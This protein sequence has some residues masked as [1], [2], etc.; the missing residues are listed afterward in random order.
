MVHR[1]FNRNSRGFLSLLWKVRWSEFDVVHLQ[2]ETFLYG[3][4]LSLFVLPLVVRWIRHS[5]P[6]VVTLHHVVHPKKIT[7]KFTDIYCTRLPP[8]LIKCGYAFFYRFLGYAATHCIVH[9]DCDQSTLTEAYGIPARKISIIPHGSEDRIIENTAEKKVL[10]EQ[11]GIPADAERIYGFL[12]YMDLSKG[13][14]MLVNEFLDHLALHPR[15][16]LLIGGIPNP[17]YVKQ[18]KLVE[19]LQ[20]LRDRTEHEGH[21]RII[22]R[23]EIPTNHTDAFY[24]LID[25]IIIPYHSFNGGSAALA[26]AISYDVPCLLSE[27]FVE[28][29]TGPAIIFSLQK[30]GLSGALHFCDMTQHLPHPSDPAFKAWREGRLWPA[31][32]AKT[33]KLYRELIMPAPRS[34]IL[35]LGAY[36][37]QNLGD[38]LLLQS[39]L[40]HLPRSSCVVA[41]AHPAETE[42]THNVRAVPSHIGF[43]L[44]RCFLRARIIVVGGGDQFKLLKKSMGR[45]RH[46]LLIRETILVVMAKLLGKKVYFI[47]VGIGAI[48]TRF[49]RLLSTIILRLADIS[50]FR[51]R[52]SARIARTLAPRAQII[53][54]ADLAFLQRSGVGASTAIASSPL[55]LGIAPVFNLDHAEAFPTVT[56]AIG[57]SIDTFLNADPNREVL[58]LPFQTG[59]QNHHDIITSGEILDHVSQRQR[60]A[61]HDH[62]DI[63]TVEQTYRSINML[64]GMRLH[65]LILACL[66]QV[67]FIALIYDVKVRKFLEEIDCAQWGIPLDES[68]SA[69]KLLSLHQKLESELPQVRL[70]LHTQAEKLKRLAQINA[71]LLSTIGT[72]AEG[73]SVPCHNPPTVH[74]RATFRPLASES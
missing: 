14:D 25:A 74:E 45:S 21:G 6:I 72:E 4:P 46:S 1:C 62:L 53:E 22:W 52:E 47:G 57:A 43:A 29:D 36:G 59:S 15:D 71:E 20:F 69:E 66:Y 17:H 8:L 48:S 18:R 23:G 19:Q 39:C 35:L 24:Q 38:E 54:S 51:D 70:H 73:I 13:I 32:S 60:C 5:V 41:S 64:W 49:A 30:G 2:H 65:S 27:A 50:S 63:V 55:R 56:H 26:R 7:K 11:F 16:V 58:F 3:G 31:V 67:P 9:E 44:L 37:Q 33:L 12:G 10:M 61:I 34:S 42:K 68:F 28:C 40:D